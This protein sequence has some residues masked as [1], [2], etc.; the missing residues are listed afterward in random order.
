MLMIHLNRQFVAALLAIWLPFFSGNSLAASVAMQ[1]IRGDCHPASAQVAMQAD[2]H[3]MQHDS[4]VHQHDQY[5]DGAD[6]AADQTGQQSSSCTDCGVCHF[7]C[8]GFLATVVADIIKSHQPAQTFDISST[9]FQSFTS[10][11]LDPPPLF[12]V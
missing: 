8:S 1:S 2:D 11:P 9:Q 10:A 7:A 3:N 4:A 5:V 12:R 6:Q